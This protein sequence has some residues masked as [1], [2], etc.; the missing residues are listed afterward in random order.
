M[1]EVIKKIYDYSLEEIMGERFARYSKTIIQ[2][3]ALPD[4]RDGLKPVQRRILYAMYKD[5][6]TFDKAYKKSAKTVGNVMGQYHPHGDSS[7]YEAMVRMSQWWKQNTILIDM[8]GNNGSMDGD[9]PAAMRYTEARLSKISNELLKDIDKGTVSWAPNYDDTLLE[10]TVLPAKFPNLIVNGSTGISAGYATN[11]PPHNLGEIINAT[12]KRIDSPNCHEDT[13][14]NIVQGPD[15]PTG[16]IVEG[17]REI[18]E[19]LTTGRGKVVVKSKLKVNEIKGKKQIIISEIP[20]EVN[21]QQLVKKIDEIRIEKRIDGILEV[22]DETDR[23]GLQIAID[24]KKDADPELIL[25]YLYK[26]TDLMVSYSYNMVAIVN[27]RPLTL[28]L[29]AMLDVY[30][31]HQR[32]IITKRTN[33]DLDVARKR[34]HIV[35]GL[36]KALSILD[37]VIKVIRSSKNR[38]DACNNLVEKF[39]FTIE[40]AQAIL[41]LQLYRLTNI[42]VVDLEEE[43]KKL[44]IIIKSLEEI[45]RDESRL[46]AV[47]KD[48]LKNIKDKY[49]TP[50]KTEIKEEVEEIKIDTTKMISKEDVV[51]IV[52]KRGYIKRVSSRSYSQSDGDTALK[53]G[54]YLIGLYKMNTLD[55]VLLFTNLGNYLYIPVHDIPDMKWKE[56]G[57]HVSNI[58]KMDPD[59]VI[60]SSMPVYDFNDEIYLTFVTKNGMIKRTKLN[61]FKVQRYNKTLTAIKLKD[62]DLLVDVSYINKD[63]IFIVTK[64]GVGLRFK[65]EEV[66]PIG[67]KGS[68]VKGISLK[69]DEVVSFSIFNK[70][71]DYLSIITE[72][73][74]GKRVKLSDFEIMTRARKGI[75]V[76]RDVKTN[77]YY[78]LNSFI[79]NNK[80]TIGIRVGNDIN[81]IKVTELPIMDRYSTGS[82]I[83]KH[84]I[85]EVFKEMILIDNLHQEEQNIDNDKDSNIELDKIDEKIMTIDDFLDDFKING[86]D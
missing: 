82:T 42:D 83:S 58:V 44:T 68:G 45:L 11:I 30:I 18:R 29:I 57:K 73:N 62:N 64:N 84:N 16:G 6:N 61:E 1:Q 22:R 79:I 49:A 60:I 3:R 15:F 76:I 51:V 56:I 24:L 37:E 10:P 75:Q 5:R 78:I 40:Q 19:A 13:I 70:N 77:P 14:F 26:N 53:D 12:I 74:T 48:E 4:A 28:G 41:D 80:S 35:S 7:I 63:E 47:M 59:E 43:N 72:K 2:D 39:E 54:D 33:F 52:S 25:N 55:T 81:K 85:D 32:D 50:R 20:F 9:G 69:N 67:T 66:A 17:K 31:A 71:D 86:L 65:L 8:H 23:A 46:K 34:L 27:G 38:Q 36:I 21:K